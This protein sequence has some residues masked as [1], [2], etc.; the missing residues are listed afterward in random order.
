MLEAISEP[1]FDAARG[2]AVVAFLLN[3]LAFL[4][5]WTTTSIQYKS[6]PALILF[7]VCISGSVANGLTFLLPFRAEL[8]YGGILPSSVCHVDQ[9]GLVMAAASLFGMVSAVTVF[10]YLV[11]LDIFLPTPPPPPLPHKGRRHRRIPVDFDDEQEIDMEV[12]SIPRR[13]LFPTMASLSASER[14]RRKRDE[15]LFTIDHSEPTETEVYIRS[16]LDRIEKV[17]AHV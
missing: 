8:C 11:D 9:A 6:F 17:L 13:I 15:M 3:A 2:A 14:A 12:S 16:R 4:W 5:V 10:T 1:Y 7:A